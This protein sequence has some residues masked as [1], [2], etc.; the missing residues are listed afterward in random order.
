MKYETELSNLCRNFH[1]IILRS[2]TLDKKLAKIIEKIGSH[3]R[4]TEMERTKVIHKSFEKMLSSMKMLEKIKFEDCKIENGILKNIKPCSNSVKSLIINRSDLYYLKYFSASSSQV[5][6]LMIIGKIFFDT[7]AN[8]FEDFLKKQT[9]LEALAVRVVNGDIFKSLAKFKENKY[10]FKIK[11]LSIDYNRWGDNASIDEAFIEFLKFNRSTLEELETEK[12]LSEKILEFVMKNLKLEKLI[13]DGTR[14]PTSPL[15]YNSKP[16]SHLKTLTIEGALENLEVARGLFHVYPKVNK[17]IIKG[18]KDEIVNEIIINIANSLKFIQYLEVPHLNFEPP[19]LP[20]ESLKTFH[21][22]FVDEV[23]NWQAFVMNNPSLE[24]LSVKWLTNGNTFTYEIID[25]ITRRL[26]NLEHVRFGAYFNATPRILEMMSQNAPKLRLV[27]LFVDNP[28]ERLV[29]T[30]FGNL[31]VIYHPHAAILL[32]FE[33]ETTLWSKEENLVISDE[34][35]NDDIMFE[36]EDDSGSN[37]DQWEDYDGD[38][39]GDY[40]QDGILFWFNNNY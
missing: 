40:D 24:K 37:I 25:A 29:N 22:D 21:V 19:E 10:Q 8:I 16:N 5:R 20:I 3:V 31:Q 39:D 2:V 18:W 38:Y 27:E 23:T 28:D 26:Q 12:T 30:T 1:T 17:L 9:I 15:V 4:I 6:Q 14:L 36:S 32:M 7:S 11:K 13:I 35:S 34:E 33:E